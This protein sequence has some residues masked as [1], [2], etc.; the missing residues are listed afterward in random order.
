MIRISRSAWNG[1]RIA[2]ARIGID[3][4][5]K[6]SRRFGISLDRV[7]VGD[8]ALMPHHLMMQIG[9]IGAEESQSPGEIRVMWRPTCP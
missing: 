3:T 4:A 1:G 5:L 6:L 2:S 7:Y 9:R 8:E